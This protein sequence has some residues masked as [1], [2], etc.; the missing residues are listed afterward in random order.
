MGHS[1]GGVIIFK[2]A[3]RFPSDGIGLVDLDPTQCR[4]SPQEWVQASN[5]E[6]TAVRWAEVRD[7]NSTGAPPGL[8]AWLRMVDGFLQ[9]PVAERAFPADPDIPTA[10]VLGTRAEGDDELS[11]W[12]EDFSRAGKAR[13]TGKWTGALAA[14]S[15]GTLIVANDAGHFVFRD[16]PGL[17]LEALRRVL[18]TP[19]QR[20]LC[21]AAQ[22]PPPGHSHRHVR[23]RNA[24]LPSRRVTLARWAWRLN[25]SGPWRAA[26][27][28]RRYAAR[29]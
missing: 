13:T 1:I 22:E 25:S 6:E 28:P 21:H 14:L 18:A 19:G 26:Y 11:W 2:Y 8:L 23:R 17:A 15:H 10:V 20:R 7:L 3:T 24:P 5:A 4:T 27:A 29:I 12:T 16:A 9:T